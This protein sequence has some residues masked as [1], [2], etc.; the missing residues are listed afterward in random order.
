MVSIKES[1]TISAPWLEANVTLAEG[2]W[3]RK[4]KLFFKVSKADARVTRLIT[5][6]GIGIERKLAKTTII[7]TLLDL[8]AQARDKAL[9]DAD[10]ELQGA[11]EDV[12]E[13]VVLSKRQK[14]ELG[15][16]LPEVLNIDAPSVD[17]IDGLTMKVLEASDRV[18]WAELCEPNLVYLHDVIMAQID[19][20]ESSKLRSTRLTLKDMFAKQTHD[21]LPPMP[22]DSRSDVEVDEK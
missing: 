6:H 11:G 19:K 9:M 7:E 22:A 20:G 12:L 14:K 16:V 3:C 2:T 4:G 1:I 21:A 17:S 18:L 5:G 10:R 13:E 15:A 8:Q